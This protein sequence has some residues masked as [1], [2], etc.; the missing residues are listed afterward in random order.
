MEKWD[1]VK[2]QADKQA[3]IQYAAERITR[4]ATATLEVNE[5]FSMALS[6]GSTPY[7]VYELLGTRFSQYLDWSRIHIWWGDERCVPIDN[8][9]NNYHNTKRAL[10]DNIEISEA[11]IHRIKI[12]EKPDK[13]AADYEAE[14]R[15]FFSDDEGLFDLNILGMGEDGHTAS[16]FP[17]TQALGEK[18]KLYIAHHVTVK[19]NMWRISQTFPTILKSSNIMYLVSGEGKA[20]ALKEVMQGEDNPTLYP[21]QTVARSNHPHIVW[22]LDKAAASK[23]D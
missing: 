17:N 5:T 9:E 2:I 15:E 1:N 4:I 21:S 7:P 20:D 16:L 3:V 12:E 6:G 22:V 8:E 18:E 11:N 19:G 23:L 10:L 14:V 13:A